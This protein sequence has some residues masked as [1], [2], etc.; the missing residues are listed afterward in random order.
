MRIKKPKLLRS[1]PL[2]YSL[3]NIGGDP[4]DLPGDED[5]ATPPSHKFRL[6]KYD[7]EDDNDDLPDHILV[8]LEQ[9]RENALKRHREINNFSVLA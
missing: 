5:L 1:N 3:I 8:K 7:P 2:R 6:I 4:S 9:I